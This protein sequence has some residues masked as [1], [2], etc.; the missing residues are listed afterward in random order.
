MDRTNQKLFLMPKAGGLNSRAGK[1][2]RSLLCHSQGLPPG[3]GWWRVSGSRI[4]GM[5][6]K[7]DDRCML[8]VPS[9]QSLTL[10]PTPHGSP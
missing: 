4:E 2:P 7:R 9:D 3:Q 1:V 10:L 6:Q 5:G 8:A